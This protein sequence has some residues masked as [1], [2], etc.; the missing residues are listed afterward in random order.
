[1]KFYSIV[2]FAVCISYNLVLVITFYMMLINGNPNIMLR[3]NMY[4]EFWIE[5]V[6]LTFTLLFSFIAFIIECRRWY[7]GVRY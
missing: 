6:F 7:I 2:A 1:M 5:I 3:A 4:N